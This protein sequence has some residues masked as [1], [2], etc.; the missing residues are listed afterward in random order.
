MKTIC[1]LHF[2]GTTK[3]LQ[4]LKVC[5]KEALFS[6]R[7]NSMN[8][9]YEVLM[10]DCLRQYEIDMSRE[11]RLDAPPL[12]PFRRRRGRPKKSELEYSTKYGIINPVIWKG[13]NGIYATIEV[14]PR[15]LAEWRTNQEKILKTQTYE[16]LVFLEREKIDWAT[17]AN[18]MVRKI[19]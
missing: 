17:V 16:E 3:D 15:T 13:P 4:Q 6:K 19:F 10:S 2:V 11:G 12:E 9:R 14:S 5:I 7:M 1:I 18:K 8:D